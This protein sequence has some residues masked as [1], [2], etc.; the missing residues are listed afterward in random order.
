M[1]ECNKWYCDTLWENHKVLIDQGAMVV[2][3][4]SPWR[5][6]EDDVRRVD[7]TSYEGQ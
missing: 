7:F 1:V 6:I 4:N 5:V 3:S 2:N